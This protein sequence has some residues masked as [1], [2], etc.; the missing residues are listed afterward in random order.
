MQL[1]KGRR[2][3]QVTTSKTHSDATNKSHF[4]QVTTSKTH[5][6]ATHKSHFRQVTTSKTHSNATHKSHFRQVTTSKT[7]SH[8][9]HK[10]PSLAQV[11]T[12]NTAM[13]VTSTL[14]KLSTMYD[15]QNTV[16]RSSHKPSSAGSFHLTPHGLM[17]LTI[18]L[19]F[20]QVTTS[21][22]HSDTTP[23]SPTLSTGNDLHSDATHK[24][25]T[26]STGNHL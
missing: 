17:E 11:T 18:V 14:I 23:E 3:R 13:R 20:Q 16:R 25:P 7:H 8:A 21:K 9:I 22:T 2:I 1:M 15:L 4:R 5:S 24:C 6:D 10:R 19:R 12:S 26:L